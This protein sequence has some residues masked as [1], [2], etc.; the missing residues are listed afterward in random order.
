MVVDRKRA[1]LSFDLSLAEDSAN[2]EK[3]DRCAICRWEVFE[4]MAHMVRSLRS[5]MGCRCLLSRCRPTAWTTT[6]VVSHGHC[7]LPRR[8]EK[9]QL[10]NICSHILPHGFDRDFHLQLVAK[11]RVHGFN[12][13]QRDHLF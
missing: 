5:K 11:L 3:K 9:R 8:A 12:A 4:S 1:S 10:D 13:G 7:C 6:R 2:F